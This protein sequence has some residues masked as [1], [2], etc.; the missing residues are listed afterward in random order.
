MEAVKEDEGPG[1]S[2]SDEEEDGDLSND[3]EGITS[4]GDAVV[5]RVEPERHASSED[6]GLDA[7]ARWTT[8]DH[9]GQEETAITRLSFGNEPVKESDR[10]S[11]GSGAPPVA[12]NVSVET[13]LRNLEVSEGDAPGKGEGTLFMCFVNTRAPRRG[14]RLF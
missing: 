2:H 7:T 12:R 14:G 3:E 1:L 8:F 10:S 9:G 4:E 6:H 13:G 11:T 5:E